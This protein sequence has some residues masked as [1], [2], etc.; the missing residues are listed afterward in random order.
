MHGNVSCAA[1]SGSA[2]SYAFWLDPPSASPF[3]CQAAVLSETQVPFISFV[4]NPPTPTG[5]AT[6]LFNHD[7]SPSTA[8]IILNAHG[9]EYTANGEL[10][11]TEFSPTTAHAAGSFRL[12]Y[13]E[14]TLTATFEAELCALPLCPVR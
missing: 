12:T 1:Y 14:G 8:S 5:P 4:L 7:A 6:I 3:G 9:V 10:T 2:P 11:L 13:A